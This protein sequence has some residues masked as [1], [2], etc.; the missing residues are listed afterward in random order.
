PLDLWRALSVNPAACLA[1]R[2][3]ALSSE[4]VIFDPTQEWTV[5]PENL[6]SR[7]HNF[8]NL[9]QALRGQVLYA[10]AATP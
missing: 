3:P 2:P 6:W 4:F 1:Q 8:P 5:T 7:S 9:P 10:H